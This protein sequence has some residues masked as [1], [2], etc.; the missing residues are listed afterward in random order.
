MKLFLLIL[1]ST[2]MP[3]LAQT[4]TASSAAQ[5]SSKD[6][7]AEAIRT[8]CINGRRCI[9]GKVIKIVPGGLVVNS[10]YTDLLKPP[11]D[12]NWVIPG[13]A[14]VKRD[15]KQLERSE[16]ASPCIGTVFLT[17]IPKRPKVKLYDYVVIMAYPAGEYLYVPVPGVQKN[18]RK[19]AAGIDTAVNL[20]LSSTD[21]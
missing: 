9:C 14:S 18:I 1:F 13:G 15:T 4:N 3:A 7:R 16:P 10:G 21:H 19:F 5:S 12:Q 20:R 11:F 6:R 17:D 2:L 8:E